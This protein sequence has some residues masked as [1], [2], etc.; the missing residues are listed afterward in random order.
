MHFLLLLSW[1][2]QREL[3]NTKRTESYLH[4]LKLTRNNKKT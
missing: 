3:N 4:N 2:G 1:K